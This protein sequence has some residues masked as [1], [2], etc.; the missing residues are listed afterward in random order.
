MD[1]IIARTASPH[2]IKRPKKPRKFNNPFDPGRRLIAAVVNTALEDMLWPQK[3]IS[4]KDRSDAVKF[5][6]SEDGKEIIHSLGISRQ[7]IVEML[8]GMRE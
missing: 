6:H 5:L 4:P 1:N 8:R 2:Q 7:R 3:N